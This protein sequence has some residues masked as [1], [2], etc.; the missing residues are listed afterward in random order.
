MA[1]LGYLLK[2]NGATYP[3]NLIAIESYKS[4]PN[5]QIDLDSYTDADGK[6]HR[7]ILDHTRTKIEFNTPYVSLAEKITVQGFFP[8]R[9]SVSVEYWNDET[10]A[11][12]TGTFYVPDITFEPYQVVSNNI[13]YKPIRVALIEY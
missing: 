2:L 10:N 8:V 3:N 6:L 1:F 11:Y 4:T 12:V 9:K 13:T 7:S 5:Q